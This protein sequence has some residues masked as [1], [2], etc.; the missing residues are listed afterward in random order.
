M[1]TFATRSTTPVGALRDDGSLDPAHAP[2]LSEELAVALYEHMILARALDEKVSALQ[3]EGV[4]T[5]PASAVG[6]EATIVGAVAAMNDEDWV[7]PSSREVA[8][9]LWRGMPLVAYAHQAFG[10]GRDVGKGRSGPG[11]P[12]WK[13]ARVASVSPLAGTQIPHAVG[14]AWAARMRAADVAALVFFDDGAASCGDFH[15]GLNF[16]GVTRAPV[17]A[18]CRNRGGPPSPIAAR[19]M[20]GA[21]FAMKAVAY[22]LHGAKVDGGD[23]VAVLS[24][25]GEA[26]RRAAAGLGGTL[27]EAVMPGRAALGLDPLATAAADALPPFE[28]TTAAPAQAPVD[29]I[30]RMRR[31]L[32][33]RGLWNPDRE[34]HL[35]DEVRADVERAVAEA[36][37]AGQPARQ[38]IFDD[39]YAELPW[40]IKEQRGD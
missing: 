15:A 12:F 6:E 19:Q 32:E 10:S 26:R 13:G 22:G 17:V 1:N 16:A 24:V 9:A 38:T 37:A 14:F 28:R 23:V 11:P 4:A 5:E 30:A 40:H 35:R 20:P 18:V 8:A 25:I 7:F 27:V 2:V 29:P 36:V 34:Q 31:H 3:C 33:S 21:G 39:V